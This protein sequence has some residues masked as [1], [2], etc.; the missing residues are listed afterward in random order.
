MTIRKEREGLEVKNHNQFI[1]Y[2]N[3]IA[4]PLAQAK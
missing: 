2:V 4:E 1:N 3:S